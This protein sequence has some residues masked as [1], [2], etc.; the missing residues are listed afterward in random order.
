MIFLGM[1]VGGT[2]TAVCLADEKG[3]IRH[4]QRI[5]SAADSQ[6]EYF[7][8]LR[9]ACDEVL[10]ACRIARDDIAAVGISAPGPLDVKRGVLIAPPNNPGWRDVP[11]VANA[12]AWFKAPVYL[13]HDGKAS[14]LAE[15]QFGAFRGAANLIYL[16]F[17]TGMGA[18]IIMNGQ[19]L[20]GSSDSCGEVGHHILD[21][22][23]PTC[24]CGMRGCWEAYVGGRNLADSVRE[25]IAREKIDTAIVA[26]AGGQLS[27]ITA[28]EI[29]LAARDGDAFAVAVWDRFT[30]RV[31]QGIG[32]LIMIFNPD[33]IILGTMAVLAGDFVMKPILDKLP[34]Y[35]WPW[36]RK[37]CRV[38]ASSLG[39]N[40]GEL[41]PIA[42]AVTA[43]QAK[44]K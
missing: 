3:R 22:D 28:R 29:E 13:Q 42:V 43:L 1:D 12:Q 39:R 4:A 14:A 23:G 25:R 6:E 34:R 31:A 17:S 32:N 15:W 40:I 36:P 7:S 21:P 16:T 27:K 5:S 33:V 8:R 10:A 24:G 38:V 41:S 9:T 37:V 44:A 26:K 35:T 2:K 19:L 18:G 30:D 11:F 20:Q